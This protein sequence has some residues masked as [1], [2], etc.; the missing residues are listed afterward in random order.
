MKVVHLILIIFIVLTLWSS[1]SLY[2]STQK[3]RIALI[4]SDNYKDS[5]KNGIGLIAISIFAFTTL[6]DYQSFGVIDKSSQ[7]RLFF[8]IVFLVNGVNSIINAYTKDSICQEY[9]ITQKSKFFWEQIS[10]YTWLEDDSDS[11]S[12]E[13]NCFKLIL[14]LNVR[15]IDKWNVTEEDKRMS[16]MI[17]DI[18]KDII[19]EHL[20]NVIR[21]SDN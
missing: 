7:G 13:F 12:Q 5:L 14:D 8:C 1:I 11:K 6:V 20:K 4:V 17:K 21:L 15:Y 19:D 3:T 18:D 16:L 9:V 10:G 2:H